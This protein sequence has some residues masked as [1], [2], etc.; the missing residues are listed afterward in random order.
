LF[1]IN[2]EDEL[3]LN[4]NDFVD[5]YGVKGVDARKSFSDEDSSEEKVCR[6]STRLI[7]PKLAKSQSKKWLYIVNDELDYRQQ[8]VAEVCE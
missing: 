3:K 5:V 8:V 1:R 4:L 6:S 7:F 2:F